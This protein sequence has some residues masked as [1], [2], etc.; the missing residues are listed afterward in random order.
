MFVV[1]GIRND[2]HYFTSVS[3]IICISQWSK[4][5]F[6]L[7]NKEAMVLKILLTLSGLYS[8]HN[9]KGKVINDVA[10]LGLLYF[11]EY[12]EF[13]EI[14]NNNRNVCFLVFLLSWFLLGLSIV[15][16]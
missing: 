5:G 3:P 9:H 8:Q 16:S 14:R 2:P 4:T 12:I 13:N 15:L 10:L 6:S 1:I 11:C 7:E